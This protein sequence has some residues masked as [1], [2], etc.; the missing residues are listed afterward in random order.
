MAHMVDDLLDVSRFT[1]G[2]VE[3]RKE[4]VS[5]TDAITRAVETA[6]PLIEARRHDLILS[7]PPEAVALDA[8]PMRLNQVFGNLLNNA[9]KYTEAGGRIWVTVARDGAEAVVRIRD[10]GIGLAP[11]ML[12]R[13]FDLFT[14]EQR[15]LDRS[16]G[17]LGIGLTLVRSLVELHGGTVK[18][19]SDGPGRGSEFVVRLPA[20][21]AGTS[22]VAELKPSQLAASRHRLLIVDDNVDSAESLAE[23]L[24][25]NGHEVRI[26]HDGAT[27][28]IE[29]QS[30]RPDVI[31]LDIGLPRMDGY[32]VARRMRQNPH[33]HAAILIAMTGYGQEED[34]RRSQEAGFDHHLIKPV[35]LAE[36]GQLLS[37]RLAQV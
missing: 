25:L 8:D 3:L 1:R 34:R 17:G 14:Q 12:T 23:V 36:L 16:Q 18:A 11:D 10:T 28:L 13:V 21:P 4:R 5:L 26:A 27:A 35:D 32:E 19:A 22:V 2:Q 33:L 20:L 6:R 7:A 9:A 37:S 31:L 30:L 29:A 24:A 15:T